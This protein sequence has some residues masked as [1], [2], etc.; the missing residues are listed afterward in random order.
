MKINF[1]NISERLADTFGD[2]E[3][4]INIE[5][6]RRYTCIEFHLFTNRIVNMMQQKLILRRGDVWLNLL[7]NDNASL[8]YRL[9]T[10][11]DFSWKYLST[12]AT[13]YYGAAPMSPSKLKELQAAFGNIFIQVYGSIE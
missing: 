9:L 5:R 4:L 6:K 2:R 1:S 3:A 12:L 10:L 7:D 8:L 11:A 13:V